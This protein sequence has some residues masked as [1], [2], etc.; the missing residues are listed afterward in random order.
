MVAL[1][2]LQDILVFWRW[3]KTSCLHFLLK[4]QNNHSLMFRPLRRSYKNSMIEWTKRSSLFYIIV[5]Q[6][7]LAELYC[8]RHEPRSLTL[9]FSSVTRLRWWY[10]YKHI[11]PVSLLHPWRFLF[12]H[13]SRA[14]TELCWGQLST[15]S[16]TC[17]STYTLR[18]IWT[19]S[20]LICVPTHQFQKHYDNRVT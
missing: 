10:L 2:L 7:V 1:L 3:T 11:G 14:L 17:S 13:I 15:S 16:A 12:W 8:T 20:Y 19:F 6:L 4:Y 18:D 5:V 9:R